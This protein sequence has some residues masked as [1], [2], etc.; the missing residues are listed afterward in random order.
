MGKNILIISSSPR[1]GNS[2]LLCDEFMRGATKSGHAVEKIRL[3][4]KKINFCT[5]C[6][7]CSTTKKPCPQKDDA[8]EIIEK[9]VQADVI[10]LASPVYFY[11][12]SAHS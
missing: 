3:A 12:M 6:E 5:G 2:D 10:V 11:A 7:V 1:R 8:A 9:M 4:E